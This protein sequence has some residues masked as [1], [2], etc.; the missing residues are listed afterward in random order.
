MTAIRNKAIEFIHEI[1][2]ERLASLLDYMQFLCE[3]KHP[4]EITS[5][6]ELYRHLDEGMD[7]IKN[8]RVYPLEDVM[9]EVHVLIDQYDV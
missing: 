2:E 1:P 6:E 8:G 9:R 7:D 5:K 4:L 3:K